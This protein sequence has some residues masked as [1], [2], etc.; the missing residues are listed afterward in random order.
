MEIFSTITAAI[1]LAGVVINYALKLEKFAHGYR[2]AQ[3]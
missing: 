2:D 3:R 1:G